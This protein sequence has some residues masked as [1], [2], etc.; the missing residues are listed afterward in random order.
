M[1]VF[2]FKRFLTFVFILVF[3]LP[4]VEAARILKVKGKKIL[5][6]QEGDNLE[7]GNRLYIISD[8]GQAQGLV[9]IV[10]VKEQKALGIISK[11]SQ[12]QIGWTLSF[13]RPSGKPNGK[14]KKL[15]WGL[16]VGFGL[17]SMSAELTNDET[18]M[19]GYG[20]SAM[21][22][23]EYRLFR[24]VW[25]RGGLG[26][27]QFDVSAEEDKFCGD[28]GD[29]PCET[30]IS[31]LSLDIW[32][33]WVPWQK[34]SFRPWIGLGARILH[35]LSYTTTAIEEFTTLSIPVF[36]IGADWHVG[37]VVIP[38]Q[39]SYGQNLMTDDV[40]FNSIFVSTGIL[41]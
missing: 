12:A 29:E 9:K 32:A 33:R 21:G 22:L 31:L 20:M 10:K 17:D 38:I 39:V 13:E 3:V 16:L 35:P 11:N 25:V 30:S 34:P 23:L 40:T 1:F 19:S 24:T 41:F 8:S 6:D 18:K 15:R 27:E 28:S 36:G 14:E 37:K 5:I 7:V 4:S 2:S 26:Y